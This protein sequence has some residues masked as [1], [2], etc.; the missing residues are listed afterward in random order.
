MDITTPSSVLMNQLTHLQNLIKRDPQGYK[1]EFERQKT[2]FL[3]ELEMFK[4]RPTVHSEKFI[5]LINFIS[6]VAPCYANFSHEIADEL[7][8]LMKSNALK[9]HSL[10]RMKLYE[11]LVFL[12]NKNLIDPH[13]LIQLSLDLIGV[14][15]KQLRVSVMD[16]IVNDVKVITLSGNDKLK[17]R[18][19]TLLFGFTSDEASSAGH[20]VVTILTIL[21]RKRIWT[22][23][24]SIN[25]LA[26]ACSSSN[27]KVMI[28]AVNFFL[29]IEEQMFFDDEAA[30]CP[31]DN[32]QKA[33][34]LSKDV[35]L[36]EHSK[37]TRKRMRD[38][39]KQHNQI[40]KLR[41]S[42]EKKQ[43]KSTPLFPAILMIHDPQTLAEKLFKKVKLSMEKIE[44]K[45]L[46]INFISRL[47]GCHNLLLLTFY[48]YLQRY[49]NSNQQNV[50]SI[51]TYLI[52]A[53]HNLVPPDELCPI[54][55]TIAM[56]FV[57]DRCSEDAIAVGINTIREIFSRVPSVLMEP[58]ME[59]LVSDL[60]LYSK[61]NHK[62]VMIAAQSL[63]NFIRDAYPSLLTKSMRGKYHNLAA[64][65]KRYGE[66]I[67]AD[68]VDGVDLLEAYEKG[69]IAINENDEI[70][71]N[72]VNQQ[73]D[74][75]SDDEEWVDVV[76]DDDGGDADIVDSTESE[77]EDGDEDDND[78]EE[79]EEDWEDISDAKIEPQE[80]Q[81]TSI[82]LDQRRMLTDDDYQLIR[83]LKAAQEK[84]LK[85]PKFRGKL[86]VDEESEDEDHP[87]NSHTFVVRENEIESQVKVR[88]A[89]K[90]ERI[91]RI[92]EGR[93]TNKF[94]HEGHAGGLTNKE[95][96]RKKNYM[97]L[98]KGKRS[99]AKKNQ[100]ANSAVRSIKSNARE[101]YGRDRRKRRRT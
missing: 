60:I 13:D 51:L 97:M 59:D 42:S 56:N 62:S 10:V 23:A 84:L 79:D 83:K 58:E 48:S 80:K 61:K 53:C 27:T 28:T 25:A 96:I 68:H 40:E 88:K 87:P 82:S 39:K 91:R 89:T 98:R 95:K 37:K 41:R 14:Q 66:A 90:I 7:T 16:Y 77:V 70:V 18:L 34:K 26:T 4:L 49:L 8:L 101:I 45:L 57:S 55:R 36:H 15:D 63:I 81:T 74:E 19:Q 11:S 1:E 2:H 76:D 31:K 50:T 52:Q 17:R 67:I 78:R 69:E 72:N 33:Q 65:P 24:R 75:H 73:N 93:K 71:W 54:V 12:R 22:D 99:I 85:D 86:S 44:V 47:I 46:L 6:H 43:E 100:L 3:S 38:I 92:L 30:D 21:Y 64:T 32:E 35:N 94:E 20:K 5:S 9:L 29:G